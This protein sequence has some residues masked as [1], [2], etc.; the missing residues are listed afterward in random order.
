MFAHARTNLQQNK[1]H[2]LKQ[3]IYELRGTKIVFKPK[4]FN[5]RNALSFL[6]LSNEITT[7]VFKIFDSKCFRVR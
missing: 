5:L 4:Y 6:H 3:K 7:A 1:I 2:R